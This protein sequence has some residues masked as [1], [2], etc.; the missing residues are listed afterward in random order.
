MSRK[1]AV[2]RELIKGPVSAS[3][4]A[5]IMGWPMRICSAWLGN[6][7]C[8]GMVDVVGKVRRGTRLSNIYALKGSA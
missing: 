6:F 7:R 3:E 4:L 1:D 2:I 5:A 8:A